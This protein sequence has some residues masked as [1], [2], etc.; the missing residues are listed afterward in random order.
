MTRLYELPACK[1]YRLPTSLTADNVLQQANRCLI[2]HGPGGFQ[3]Q[4]GVELLLTLSLHRLGE[5]EFP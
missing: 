1:D 4:G 3:D 2:G 5:I